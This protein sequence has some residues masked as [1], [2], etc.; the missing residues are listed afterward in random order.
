ML[1]ELKVSHFAIIANMHIEFRKGLN[2]ISGET[3]AGKSILLKSLGLLMG[4]KAASDSVRTGH[5]SAVI[6]GC[7][8][9]SDRPDL[10][11]RLKEM[12]IEALD[13]QMIVRRVVSTSNKSRIYINTALC[14]LSDLRDLVAPLVELTGPAVPLIEM[15]GQH[16]NRN[17]LSR[18][19]HLDLLDQFAGNWK[20]RSEFL[21]LSTTNQTMKRDIEELKTASLT[22]EQRLD[23]LRF[24]RDEIVA[25]DLKPGEDESIELEAKRIKNSTKLVE[26]I[27]NT[28]SLL[29]GDDDSV[30]GRLHYILHR[31]GEL[32]NV[33]PKLFEKLEPLQQ[34]KTLI[35]EIAYELRDYQKDLEADPERLDELERRLS[36]LRQLQK[37]Y[38]Q[39]AEDIL[40]ALEKI[41]AEIHSLENADDLLRGKS[42]AIS[43]L[44]KKMLEL[45][46][47]L[48]G[49]REKASSLLARGVN[50]ELRDLNMKGVVLSVRVARLENMNSS[51]FTEVEFGVQSSKNEPARSLAKYASGG[52]LSRIL[53]AIKQ[54]TGV[55]HMPRTYLF[56]EVDTGVS[57][58]TAEKVGQKLKLIAKGQQ[59]ICVTHLPQVAAAGDTH[60]FIEKSQAGRDEQAAIKMKITEISGDHRTREI[61][62]LISG[63]KISKT[64]LAHAQTLLSD[65]NRERAAH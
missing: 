1:L 20:Q 18:S 41:V 56:D 50:E 53:L 55:G 3:G 10:Q 30:S 15:T 59:V 12:G 39:T 48:H 29:Y 9:I 33:D 64:S 45:S 5:E 46:L 6:E 22:R 51:G 2:I 8:D 32:K 37:K 49:R 27:S 63:E 60:F 14:N 40:L 34:A 28:E 26:F 61:A 35:N 25:L 4:D 16:E 42:I 54:V 31:A 38:G 36:G 11:A 21:E 62:R 57:G 52:E 7:F 43:A 23:F 47:L 13:E 17:L 65:S 44:E 24:Q 58:E 19:Y